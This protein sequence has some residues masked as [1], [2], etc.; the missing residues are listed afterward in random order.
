[1][2]HVYLK[3]VSIRISNTRKDKNNHMLKIAMVHVLAAI[4]CNCIPSAILKRNCT[5]NLP[6]S[7]TCRLYSL[8]V[9]FS[10]NNCSF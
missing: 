10:L 1:M 3:Y 9:A 8:S 6:V 2:C 5:Y 4:Y 7:A